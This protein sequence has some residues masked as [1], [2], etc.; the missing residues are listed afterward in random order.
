MRH[1]KGK[2]P[3]AETVL[4]GEVATS[5]PIDRWF[6][7][8]EFA[9]LTGIKRRSSQQRVNCLVDDGYLIRE[10]AEQV[11][12]NRFKMSA[13]SKRLMIEKGVSNNRNKFPVNQK[14][15]SERR[16]I[17]IAI[18]EAYQEHAERI[19]KSARFM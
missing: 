2:T 8:D 10:K 18:T 13:Q 6:S 11:R 7:L 9:E 19:L 14:Q 12:N 17:E 16:S 15:D 4:I 1:K 5:L 3:Q